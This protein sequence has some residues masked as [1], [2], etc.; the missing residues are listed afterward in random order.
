PTQASSLKLSDAIKRTLSEHPSL[1]VFK[2]RQAAL[3]GQQQTQ[4]LT[5]AYEVAF[6]VEDLS[7]TGNLNKL[8]NAQLTVSLSSIVEMGGKRDA[9]V[10]VVNGRR[11]R[12]EAQQEIEGLN[13]LGEVTRRYI[14]VL[15]VQERLALATYASEL[16]EETLEEAQKRVKAGIAP[17]AEIKRAMAAIGN[18]RLTASSERQQLDYAKRALTLMWNKTTPQ[19]S[20]VE[21][22]LFHFGA[23][24]QFDLLFAK[25]KQN[26]AIM[27]LASEKRL[28]EAQLR[29]A[30]TQ[31]SANISWSVG[32]KHMLDTNETALIAGFSMPLFAP[33]RHSGAMAT[34]QAARDEVVANKEVTL[35]KLRTQL[36]RAYSNRKQAIFTVNSL[37]NSI[38]PT[39]EQALE[40]TQIAF[41]R[42]VYSY[43]DY[44]TARQELL[45]AR[46]ALIESASA[47]LRYGADIEQLIAEPLSHPSPG[48]R[49]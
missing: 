30:D 24:I 18:A 41:Q 10:D 23:D 34:A 17:E 36:Y 39:L 2:F 25:V 37:K 35:L 44:L 33:N 14:L 49:P 5:P 19:F 27:L 40:Q 11:S 8:D 32:F 20:R 48:V 21:G 16:A 6:E 31:S 42:G 9:R 12:L 22:D 7:P 4:A 43:L 28:K 26:P 13:L 3:D 15:S 29:L 46:R 1:K 45:F 38:I 47:A